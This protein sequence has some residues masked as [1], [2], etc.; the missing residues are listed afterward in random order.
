MLDVLMSWMIRYLIPALV[1]LKARFV[2]RNL[3]LCPPFIPRRKQSNVMSCLSVCKVS[4]I[5]VWFIKKAVFEEKSW[6]KY[7]I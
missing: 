4:V 1:S 3:C 5:F 2:Y 7:Q 6:Q